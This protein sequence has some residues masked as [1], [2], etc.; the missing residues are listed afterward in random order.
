M[1]H[2]HL[3][4]CHRNSATRAETRTSGAPLVVL[5]A[6]DA[7][8]CKCVYF[9]HEVEHLNMGVSG[10]PLVFGASPQWDCSDQLKKCS[11][12][13][14]LDLI[15]LASWTKPLGLYTHGQQSLLSLQSS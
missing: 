9:C 3:R 11:F 10:D 4:R 8:D 12:L 15:R 6:L 2:P 14:F 1:A 7:L 5:S 13:H